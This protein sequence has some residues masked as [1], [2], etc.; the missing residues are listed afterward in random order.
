MNRNILYKSLALI[1]FIVVVKASSAFAV[2]RECDDLLTSIAVLEDTIDDQRMSYSGQL[3]KAKKTYSSKCIQEGANGDIKTPSRSCPTKKLA[4]VKKEIQNLKKAS[5]NIK[6]MVKEIKM[7]AKKEE[8]ICASA[9]SP[10]CVVWSCNSIGY[11]ERCMN[12]D[13]GIYYG[14][15]SSQLITGYGIGKDE[16][17]AQTMSQVSCSTNLSSR[18]VINNIGGS[19]SIRSPCTVA[20]C[21]SQVKP[22]EDCANL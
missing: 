2:S 3:S 19:G 10:T 9:Q 20:G 6:L 14:L 22:S 7:L 8:N 17:S 12:N 16:F 4:K 21:S 1:I 11:A 15:C 5:K 18:V 13:G